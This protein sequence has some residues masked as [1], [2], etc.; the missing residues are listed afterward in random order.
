MKSDSGISTLRRQLLTYVAFLLT[1]VFMGVGALT[2]TTATAAAATVAVPAAVSPTGE[3]IGV[4]SLGRVTFRVA[5][6]PTAGTLQMST[7]AR[8]TD[9]GAYA[10]RARVAADGT[11]E[12]SIT[13]EAGGD[14]T[15]LSERK[16]TGKKLT[17]GSTLVLRLEATGTTEVKLSA[18]VSHNSAWAGVTVTDS[19]DARLTTAG[20]VR[21]A[22]AVSGTTP[23]P[24]VYYVT[25]QFSDGPSAT[26]PN[27]TNTGVPAGTQ[28]TRYDGNIYIDEPNTVIEGLEVHGIIKV[29]APGAVIKNSKIVGGSTPTWALISNMDNGDSFTVQNVELAPTVISTKWNGIY[30]YNFTA[31][32]VNAHHVVDGFRVI[33]SNVRITDSWV[34]DQTYDET[35]PERGGTPTHD[36]SIQ[37]Q[38]GANLLFE[39][40]RFESSHNAAIMFTQLSGYDKL[41]N[42]TIRNNYLNDGACTINIAA[43]SSPFHAVITDNVFGPDRKVAGCSTIATTANS[44]VMS[45]TTWAVDGRPANDW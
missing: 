32:R 29:R 4:N 19:S 33:G 28:L 36:D 38:A 21:P 44:P 1:I 41:D 42:V 22:T 17:A 40:N 39:G 43:T 6:L 2:A 30:G 18:A 35:D 24:A 37:V 5:Q 26:N 31:T 8:V 9:S 12:L 16:L 15:T 14:V 10:A 23:A 13:R 25:A 34:H 20:A 45:G 3:Q 27:A 11:V 7:Q